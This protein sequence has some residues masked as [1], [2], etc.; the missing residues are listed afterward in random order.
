MLAKMHNTQRQGE[1]ASRTSGSSSSSNNSNSNNNNNHKIK[2]LIEDSPTD[3]E[4]R[5][6]H[7][8]ESLQA[9][10][11]AQ[12]QLIDKLQAR[13]QFLERVLS[14][15]SSS[16]SL[17]L[18]SNSE[19]RVSR[20]ESQG[21]DAALSHTMRRSIIEEAEGASP[22]HIWTETMWNKND[23][24]IVI[25]TNH[26]DKGEKPLLHSR[27]PWQNFTHDLAESCPD[28]SC[29][30]LLHQTHAQTQNHTSHEQDP[31]A[32]NTP[33]DSILSPSTLPSHVGRRVLMVSSKLAFLPREVEL[34][35]DKEY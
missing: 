14:T 9:E 33:V 26:S 30:E 7:V 34:G 18:S 4:Q 13:A 28:V 20:C 2:C 1:V 8:V 3:S 6:Q 12:R 17:S 24:N 25:E 23:M 31:Q 35:M 21:L 15:S 27:N 16:L 11:E 32:Q 10:N 5:W 29:Q 19:R 22:I